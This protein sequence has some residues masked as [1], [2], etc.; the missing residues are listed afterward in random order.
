MWGVTCGVP[1]LPPFP[2][3][4]GEENTS[5]STSLQEYPCGL[6]SGTMFGIFHTE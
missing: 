6:C 1:P 3:N 4:G 2:H 5:D